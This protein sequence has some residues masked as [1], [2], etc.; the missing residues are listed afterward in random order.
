MKRWQGCRVL[1][2]GLAVAGCNAPGGDDPTAREVTIAT[3]FG[4]RERSGSTVGEQ[5]VAICNGW[6]PMTANHVV[7]IEDALNMTVQA[8]SAGDERLWITFGQSNFC[9]EGTDAQAV[10]RFWGTGTVQVYVGTATQG[11]QLDYDLEFI[12]N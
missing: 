10:M 9:G 3:G 11:A 4:T 12:E 6:F 7:D 2:L 8:S 5:E 1:A